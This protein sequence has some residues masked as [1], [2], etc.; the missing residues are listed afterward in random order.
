MPRFW[1]RARRWTSQGRA[2][3]TVP[4]RHRWCA[5]AGASYCLQKLDRASLRLHTGL[6][7]SAESV[8]A[9]PSPSPFHCG[10]TTLQ[11][12]RLD[13]LLLQLRLGVHVFACGVDAAAVGPFPGARL[14][15]R[16][17]LQLNSGREAGVQRNP[18]QGPRVREPHPMAM[19]SE[20]TC[21]ARSRA[22]LREFRPSDWRPCKCR[23]SSELLTVPF[24]LTRRR[25]TASSRPCPQ[26]ERV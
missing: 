15:T 11:M 6:E 7:A 14:R 21:T 13:L 8:L 17:S 24:S 12:A 20:L 3:W 25:Q 4:I 16:P 10:A 5:R 19:S 22:A 1:K 26:T 18:A 23:S 2:P 9:I